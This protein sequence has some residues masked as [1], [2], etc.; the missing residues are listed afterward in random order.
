MYVKINHRH[1][2]GII[3]SAGIKSCDSGVVEKA[4]SH[5]AV[6]FGVVAGWAHGKESVLRFAFEYGIDRRCGPAYGAQ[7]GGQGS[8][9]HDG[10]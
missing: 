2:L 7:N 10:V 8:G 1:A 9:R 3:F 6:V 5:G 4:E